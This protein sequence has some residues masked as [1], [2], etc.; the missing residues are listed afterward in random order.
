MIEAVR[1]LLRDRA[2]VA[3][4]FAEIAWK[5]LMGPDRRGELGV[6]NAEERHRRLA[7]SA[8]EDWLDAG[9]MH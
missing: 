4:A 8:V 9:G 2:R 6:I 5:R 3:P 7:R 1:R